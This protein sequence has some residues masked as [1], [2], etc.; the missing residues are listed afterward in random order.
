M[1]FPRKLLIES[2][3]L[4]LELR[5]HWIALVMPAIVTILVIV[6][7]PRGVVW[8]RQRHGPRRHVLGRDRDRHLRPD[9]VPGA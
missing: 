7:V 3:Q 8:P 2:E 1:P 5:P 9:L 4:V 6:A